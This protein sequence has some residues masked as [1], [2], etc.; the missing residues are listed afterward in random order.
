LKQFCLHKGGFM[1]NQEAYKQAK[2][3]VE[4]RY[5]FYIHLSVY[6][7]V[8]LLLVIINLSSSSEGFWFQYPLLGWG[9]GVV[10]HALS[11]FVFA[12][13]GSLISEDMIEKE[14]NREGLRK[15]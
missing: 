3:R 4:A 10:F 2:K 5:G 11:V 12:G 7:A 6:L 8:N 1:N 15:T 9:I 13:R 14:M